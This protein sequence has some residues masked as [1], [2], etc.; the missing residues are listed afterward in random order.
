M[1]VNLLCQRQGKLLAPR[2]RLDVRAG[3]R[4]GLRFLLV[5]PLLLKPGV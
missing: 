5:R 1:G 4:W 3:R 2:F